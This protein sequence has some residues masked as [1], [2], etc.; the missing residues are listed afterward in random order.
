M[1]FLPNAALLIITPSLTSAAILEPPT[2]QDWLGHPIYDKCT[3]ALATFIQTVTTKR[4]YMYNEAIEF[5]SESTPRKHPHLP[6]ETFTPEL[7]TF[8]SS[9]IT[10]G[11]LNG[12]YNPTQLST[13][14]VSL[15]RS[16]FPATPFFIVDSRRSY[17]YENA[18]DDCVLTFGITYLHG[19]HDD[20]SF[21]ATYADLFASASSIIETCVKS[22]TPLLLGTGGTAK[23]ASTEP[24]EQG[25]KITPLVYQIV[26]TLSYDLTMAARTSQ[27]YIG[28][29]NW[30]RNSQANRGPS[31]FGGSTSGFY[32]PVSGQKRT[33]PA[34][35]AYC[36]AEV[37]ASCWPGF[38]CKAL[39]L[40]DSIKDVVWG[41]GKGRGLDFIGS[42]ILGD[43]GS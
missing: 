15:P 8:I 26:S 31:P 9:D 29:K 40:V 6:A 10:N 21:V 4:G 19:R 33:R 16:L 24:G 1:R 27:L 5:L 34:E 13:L 25:I 38:G 17:C 30:A 12:T 28:S 37:E 3:Y 43:G 18:E 35:G 36:N 42:C 14:L 22:P 39:R 20:A 11:P 7:N 23:I 32:T 2:C 41:L